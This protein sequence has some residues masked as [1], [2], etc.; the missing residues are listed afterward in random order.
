MKMESSNGWLSFIANAGVIIGIIFLA[1][2]LQQNNKQLALQ[3][4]QSW[5]AENLAINAQLTDPELSAIVA[6]GYDDS[7]KLSDETYIAFAMHQISMLQMAQSTDYLYRA[8]SLD[9]DLWEAEMSRAAGILSAVGV[10][11]WWDAGGRTQL[12][13]QFVEFIESV[14][15]D[16]TTW[17]WAEDRGYY[18]VSQ[19]AQSSNEE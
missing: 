7:T 11:Q 8:G 10:R 16:I 13:P 2:E 15:T 12:T 18:G 9:K 1:Y 17:R 5:A 19:S 6:R 4:Y 3:S 14:Q